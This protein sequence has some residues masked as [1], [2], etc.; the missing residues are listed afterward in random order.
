[1]FVIVTY[2]NHGYG[3]P[4]VV[5]GP[6]NDAGEAHWIADNLPSDPWDEVTYHVVMELNKELDLW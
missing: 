4:R 6:Y 3:E 2:G 5:R 1:M